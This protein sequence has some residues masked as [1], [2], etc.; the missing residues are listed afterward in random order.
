MPLPNTRMTGRIENETLM[1]LSLLLRASTFVC[2]EQGTPLCDVSRMLC[3]ANSV[4]RFVQYRV[5]FASHLRVC[6]LSLLHTFDGISLRDVGIKTRHPRALVQTGDIGRPGA[7][8]VRLVAQKGML[9]QTT[10]AR[11][12]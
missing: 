10:P 6:P 12:H 7:Y 8:Q 5:S 11:K 9:S 4:L 1:L 3:V 2:G